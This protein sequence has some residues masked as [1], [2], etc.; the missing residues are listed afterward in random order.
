MANGTGWQSAIKFWGDNPEKEADLF[1]KMKDEIQR[2]VEGFKDDNQ[3]TRRRPQHAKMI[4]GIKNAE[5]RMS[6][7]IPED[8]RV[9]FLKPSMVYRTYVRFSSAHGTI[10]SDSKRDLRGVAIRVK[11]DQPDYHDF[12]MTN[13]ERHHAK[14][15][16][17]AMATAVELSKGVLAGFPGLVKRVG[18]VSAF[19]ILLTV[20]L[21]MVRPIKSIA[22][23]TYWSRAPLAI[24]DVAVKYLLKPVSQK[25]KPARSKDKLGEELKHRIERSEIRFEFQVQRYIDE[26]QTPLENATR[27][28]ASQV[29]TIA[30]LV[31]PQDAEVVI[32]DYDLHKDDKG[33]FEDLEFNPWHVN[34]D[35]FKPIGSMNR[36]RRV[37]YPESVKAR[38]QGSA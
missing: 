31:I 19:R 20:I 6:S 12:L 30:E 23:E 14:D 4:A 10:K 27:K 26:H 34:T 36:F 9:G 18:T 15:A 8:L 22:A 28:W 33:F 35:E 38:K 17:E 21:Q 32:P 37:V 16:S 7:N 3:G 2:V 13:A 24:G 29:E 5:F 25:S 1:E 11:A